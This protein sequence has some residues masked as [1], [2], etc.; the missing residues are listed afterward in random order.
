MIQP[1]MVGKASQFT[2]NLVSWGVARRS[3]VARSTLRC[4]GLLVT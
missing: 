4:N 3:K 2:M 1:M